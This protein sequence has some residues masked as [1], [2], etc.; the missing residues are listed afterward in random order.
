MITFGRVLT[1]LDRCAAGRR[2]APRVRNSMRLL[3]SWCYNITIHKLLHRL[4]LVAPQWANNAKITSLWHQND[5]ATSFWRHND[6]IFASCVRWFG[7][8]GGVSG[9]ASWLLNIQKEISATATDYGMPVR[10]Q[11]II[12]TNADAW[13]QILV[14]M[15]SESSIYIQENY[16]GNAVCEWWPHIS[17]SVWNKTVKL[18]TSSVWDLW[19]RQISTASSSLFHVPNGFAMKHER[20]TR[21]RASRSVKQSNPAARYSGP[22]D[23]VNP[24]LHHSPDQL[25]IYSSTRTAYKFKPE[26]EDTALHYS[27]VIMSAMASQITGV[28][29]VYSTVCSGA[30]QGKHQSSTS[31]ASVRE[32]HRWPMK[33]LHKG[34][35][36]RKMFPFDDVIMRPMLCRLAL[37]PIGVTWSQTDGL[38]RQLVNSTLL[39]A[40]P[41]A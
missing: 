37:P 26:E 3:R 32:T 23:P 6:V 22:L 18:S 11:A 12:G 1:V 39:A 10:R 34:P 38:I 24:E 20:S 35:V 9:M 17:F 25:L 8:V 7:S 4:S 33:S 14:K 40:L 27:D 29:I 2:A 13:E 16:F 30:D 36:K 19:G 15:K 41:N 28:S 21:C 31:L 5:V